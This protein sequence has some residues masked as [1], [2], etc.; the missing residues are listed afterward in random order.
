MENILGYLVPAC[1]NPRTFGPPL[2]KILDTPPCLPIYF[3]HPL[4]PPLPLHSPSTIGTTNWNGVS[5]STVTATPLPD[6]NPSKVQYSLAAG[7]QLRI[8][9]A[10]FAWSQLQQKERQWQRAYQRRPTALET[11]AEKWRRQK[12]AHHQQ[13]FTHAQFPGGRFPAK[14]GCQP[15][16]LELYPL[17]H[18]HPAKYMRVHFRHL[19]VYKESRI[20]YRA[21][22][23]R[24]S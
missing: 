6:A 8:Y 10:A 22:R 4:S 18:T 9:R 15:I 21:I 19:G 5:S 20:A 14:F 3:P 17:T 12:H 1:Q 13:Q 2:P 16:K 11:L 7:H 23:V 24:V